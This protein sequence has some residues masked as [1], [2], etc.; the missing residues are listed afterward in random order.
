MPFTAAAEFA[1]LVSSN[2]R[3]SLIGQETAG[4]YQGSSGGKSV[5]VTLPNSKLALTIPLWN[6]Y[7]EV[8]DALNK[9]R[10]VMPQFPAM[11]TTQDLLSGY[12]RELEYTFDLIQKNNETSQPKTAE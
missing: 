2:K 9:N 6:I 4:G 5:R 7:L 11:P 1:A 8:D 10:G 3:G 12:D